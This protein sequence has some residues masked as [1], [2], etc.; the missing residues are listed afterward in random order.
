MKFENKMQAATDLGL[1]QKTPENMQLTD[2]IDQ[3][4]ARN[5]DMSEFPQIVEAMKSD[6]RFKKH[7]GFIGLRKLLSVDNPP[8][9]TVIDAN[10][11]P[12][13]IEYMQKDDEPHLQVIY[14]GNYQLS[15]I[16]LAWKR[17]GGY[18]FGCRY[19]PANQIHHW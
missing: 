7:F 19:I 18:E 1:L 16:S 12:I 6:D 15:N 3:L 5:F 13:L 8:I 11:L 4:N 9:Q 17:L 2:Y 10:V 14:S